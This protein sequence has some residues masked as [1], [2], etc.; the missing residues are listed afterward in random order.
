M[1]DLIKAALTFVI[2][3]YLEQLEHGEQGDAVILTK[4][5]AIIDQGIKLGLVKEYN[6]IPF[7]KE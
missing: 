2:D 6:G 4:A 7:A 5:K 3:V 1:R